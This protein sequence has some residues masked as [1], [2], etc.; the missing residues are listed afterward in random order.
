MVEARLSFSVR[1][2]TQLDALP[3][4]LDGAGPHDLERRPPSGKWSARENLAHL[5]RYHEVFLD[6]LACMRRE[7]RPRLAR[8][9]AE[10]DPE[11]PQWLALPAD[12]VLERLRTLRAEL[13]ATVSGL[14]PRELARTG[15]HPAFGEMTV[16]LWLEFFLVHEAHHLYLVLQRV[17]ER[18]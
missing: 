12:V 13:L 16:A 6:R 15:V 8:Y 5:A 4:L 3:L 2:A 10:E 17:R 7:Q 9:R 14:T 18:G 1:L 11:F